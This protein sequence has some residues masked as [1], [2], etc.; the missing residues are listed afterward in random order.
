MTTPTLRELQMATMSSIAF[1]VV[2][3]YDIFVSNFSEGINFEPWHFDSKA[4]TV[5][6]ERR[7]EMSPAE[8][9]AFISA[10]TEDYAFNRTLDVLKLLGR[11]HIVTAYLLVEMFR[12][13][14]ALNDMDDDFCPEVPSF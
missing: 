12:F 9:D 13:V 1:E 7:M 6:H 2:N 11:A 10:G 8:L 14:R 5:A 4:L 3:S